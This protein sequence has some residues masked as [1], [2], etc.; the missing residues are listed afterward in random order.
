M[1]KGKNITEQQW[2][3]LTIGLRLKCNQSYYIIAH[4]QIHSI[5]NAIDT[6]CIPQGDLSGHVISTS[7]ADKE[8]TASPQPSTDSEA[9]IQGLPAFALTR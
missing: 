7:N 5:R 6:S 9:L 2:L 1:I 3:L 4:F 8:L